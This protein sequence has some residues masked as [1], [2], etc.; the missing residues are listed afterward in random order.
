MVD[1]GSEDDT[2]EV[3]ARLVSQDSRL[4]YVRQ[5]NRGMSAA[6]NHGLRLSTGRYLQF[7]DADDALQPRKLETHVAF[8]EGHGDCSIVHGRWAYWDGIRASVPGSSAAASVLEGVGRAATE[9][10]LRGNVIAVN[11]AL[12]RAN[13]IKA[14]GPFDESLG[15][16]EDWEFWLRLALLGHRFARAEGPE[17]MALVRIHRTSVSQDRRRMLSG[18]IEVRRRV[19][20]ELR[21]PWQRRLNARLLGEAEV[22][23]GTRVGVHDS[24]GHGMALVLRGA[25]RGRSLRHLLRVPV[26]P[27]IASGPG[28]AVGRRLW[29]RLFGAGD[30]VGMPMDPKERAENVGSD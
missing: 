1:D 12:V 29:P 27:L 17:S 9:L 30:P 10:L 11:A 25:L 4:R 7:L 2:A 26:L 19:R 16:H 21:E 20:H 3:M 22:W 6:R 14:A 23:L 8:L 13:A 15:A 24:L 5:A 28:A 18:A